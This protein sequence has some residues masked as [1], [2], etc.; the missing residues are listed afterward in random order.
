M[1]MYLIRT[2]KVHNMHLIRT[3][4]V[5]NLHHCKKL[6]QIR[7]QNQK[8]SRKS[9]KGLLVTIE[10]KPDSLLKFRGEKD[11]YQNDEQK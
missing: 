8:S 4:K 5:H 10:K 9:L 3:K 7:Y 11:S 2:K 1:N 6:R